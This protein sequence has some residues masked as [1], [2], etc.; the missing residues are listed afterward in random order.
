[1]HSVQLMAVVDE[2]IMPTDRLHLALHAQGAPSANSR[3][4][5]PTSNDREPWSAS[6]F[7]WCGGPFL[8]RNWPRSPGLSPVGTQLMPGTSS[9]ETAGAMGSQ[10]RVSVDTLAGLSRRGGRKGVAPEMPCL[11]FSVG[12]KIIPS[13]TVTHTSLRH[14]R[15]RP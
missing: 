9:R 6:P 3:L 15:E 14:T 7:R 11:A 10:A 5:T 8:S 2:K 13:P 4:L 12:H 1:M